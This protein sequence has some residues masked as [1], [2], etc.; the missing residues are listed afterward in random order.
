MTRPLPFARP[1]LALLTLAL[2]ACSGAEAPEAPRPVMVVQAVP[3]LSGLEAFAGE[4][5]A[6][7]EPPLSFRI[8]GKIARRLVDAGSHVRAGQVLAELDPTDV[9]LQAD[10][11]RAQQVSAES[12]LALAKAELDRYKNL[13]DQQLVSRSL[14]D[15]KLAAYR[16]ADARVRQARA[17]SSVYGNQASYAVLRAPASGL[18][19]QRQAEAGQV[20]AA[21]QTVFVLAVDGE[22]E[23]AISLPE[24]TIRQFAVGRDMAVELWAAPGKRFPGKLREL[25]PAADPLTRT[26]AARVSFAAPGIAVDIGQSAR[27]YAQEADGNGMAVPLSALVQQGQGSAVWVVHHAAAGDVV[28]LTPVAI[29]AFGE[30]TVPVRSGLKPGDWVVAAGAHL[31]REGQPVHPVDRDD[32]AVDVTAPSATATH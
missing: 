28:H 24:Q 1:L 31:L 5:H 10:A 20:V 4:V 7:E 27:V 30:T 3:G 26:Y 21:G 32:R 18:I 22:R 19:A 9:R 16:A 12:D 14:Y 13:V 15:A 29:G 6:R 23:V 11:Y 17:Q 8:G 25:A 2:V